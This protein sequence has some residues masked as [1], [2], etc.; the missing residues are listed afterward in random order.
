MCEH[1]G[2]GGPQEDPRRPAGAP[3]PALWLVLAALIAILLHIGLWVAI[4]EPVLAGG[5]PPA[6]LADQLVE[7]GMR[8][9]V[10]YYALP[11]LVA[12][13]LAL[14]LLARLRRR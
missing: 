3:P 8:T 12:L 7:P 4:I 1:V 13:L 2:M 5:T 6:W 11:V 10:L 9:R 14:S